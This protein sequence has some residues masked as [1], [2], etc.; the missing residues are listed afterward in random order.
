MFSFCKEQQELQHILEASQMQNLSRFSRL[1]PQ[2]FTA[3][4]YKSI[5]KVCFYCYHD[6]DMWLRL[7]LTASK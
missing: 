6:R 3:I 5:Y 7:P 1:F 2:S 4:E